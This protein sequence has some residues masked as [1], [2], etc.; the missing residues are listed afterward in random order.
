MVVMGVSGRQDLKA[1]QVIRPRKVRSREHWGAVA[2]RGGPRMSMPPWTSLTGA[3]EV[4]MGV[5][6]ETCLG[7]GSS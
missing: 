3:T 7:R 6:L 2:S 4:G 5:S 1:P